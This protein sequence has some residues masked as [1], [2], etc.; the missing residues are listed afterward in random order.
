MDD[1][2]I[3]GCFIKGETKDRFI[4][5]TKEVSKANF[6]NH[7]TFVPFYEVIVYSKNEI[8]D[9][10]LTTTIYEFEEHTLMKSL[11]SSQTF[12]HNLLE[13]K[14]VN[15]SDTVEYELSLVSMSSIGDIVKYLLVD[16]KGLDVKRGKDFEGYLLSKI[17][18]KND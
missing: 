10:N 7:R 15:E 11:Q 1:K 3:I 8:D 17:G 2:I 9:F 12:I 16:K 13:K 4:M 14:G 5:K 18:S 6:I